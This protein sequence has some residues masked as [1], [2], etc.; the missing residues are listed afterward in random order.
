[1]L[2]VLLILKFLILRSQS[3][4]MLLREENSLI[5]SLALFPFLLQLTSQCLYLSYH[6]CLSLAHDL[7]FLSNLLELSLNLCDIGCSCLKFLNPRACPQQ[8]LLFPPQHVLPLRQLQLILLSQLALLVL[9]VLH[10]AQLLPHLR[11]QLVGIAQM[12]VQLAILLLLLSNQHHQPLLA[13]YLFAQLLTQ[14]LYF[15]LLPFDLP[16]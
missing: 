10:P 13:L 3:S 15:R 6:I 11:V 1:M 16:L 14:Y 12:P 2:L 7:H 9:H 8:L 4:E 5:L